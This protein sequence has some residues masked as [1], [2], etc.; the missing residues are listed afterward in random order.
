MGY[1]LGTCAVFSRLLVSFVT[2]AAWGCTCCSDQVRRG[3]T[4]GHSADTSSASLLTQNWG[5]SEARMSWPSILLAASEKVETKRIPWS[6]NNYNTVWLCWILRSRANHPGQNSSEIGLSSH[7][8]R[9][10]SMLVAV[11]VLRWFVFLI[12]ILLQLPALKDRSRDKC[13]FLMAHISE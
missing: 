4:N 13:C 7:W 10:P 12:S 3:P 1:L 11:S 6:Q 9:R 8:V 2:T 5:P